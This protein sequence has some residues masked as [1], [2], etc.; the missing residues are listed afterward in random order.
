MELHARLILGL[1]LLACPSAA[2]TCGPFTGIETKAVGQGCP[3]AGSTPPALKAFLQP[4]TPCALG[5]EIANVDFWPNVYFSGWVLILGTAPASVPVVRPG[6]TLLAWPL[7]G[8]GF[9]AATRRVL[10]PLPPDPALLGRTLYLQGVAAYVGFYF[11]PDLTG[12]LAA[13]LR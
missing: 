9:D 13:T 8:L 12:G 3:G 6:C 1:A 5:V 11:G 10:L 4:G 7:L 2:Q